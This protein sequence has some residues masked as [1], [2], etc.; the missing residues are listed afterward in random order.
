ML[1]RHLGNLPNRAGQS[2]NLNTASRQSTT[3][4][5]ATSTDNLVI[6]SQLEIRSS[7]R[8]SNRQPHLESLEVESYT[9]DRLSNSWFRP[10]SRAAVCIQNNAT[11]SI[12]N[13]NHVSDRHD[14]QS[15]V[16]PPPYES[17][18]QNEEIY[19]DYLVTSEHSSTANL[20][21]SLVRPPNETNETNATV[22][23]DSEESVSQNES[24]DPVSSGQVR[25]SQHLGSAPRRESFWKTLE[26]ARLTGQTVDHF[27][28]ET[29]ESNAGT[30]GE[31]FSENVSLARSEE[32]DVS[33]NTGEIEERP[34]EPPS[35]SDLKDTLENINMSEAEKEEEQRTANQNM[36][37]PF[38][39]MAMHYSYP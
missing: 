10:V 19:N 31:R 1:E 32:S 11:N 15:P 24:N 28:S 13:R 20:H 35:Y 26:R 12:D 33:M 23:E 39:L 21:S 8:S 25:L 3:P 9:R 36:T 29:R 7:I 2:K 27:A 18:F 14:C 37:S 6:Q 16:S 34:I 17:L 5:N 30:G 38:Y 4:T 22:R